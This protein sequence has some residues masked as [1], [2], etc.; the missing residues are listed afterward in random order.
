MKEKQIVENWGRVFNFINEPVSIH[1]RDFRIIRANRAFFDLLK[2]PPEE[3]IGKHCYRLLHDSIEPP[4]TCPHVR[5][6][7]TKS[8]ETGEV[9]CAFTGCP[10]EVSVS[11]IFDEDMEL[12]GTVHIIR[13]ITARKR[14]EHALIE[15][16]ERHRLLLKH[17]D[18][19]VMVHHM[20]E[21]VYINDA[22][23]R[24]V[25]A[26]T[27]GEVIGMNV[28]DFVHPD[29]RKFVK[30]R[31]QRVICEQTPLPVAEEKLVRLDGRVLYA[32]VSASPVT[33]YGRP[34]VQV[35]VRDITERKRAEE[36]IIK[37]NRELSA[38]YEVSSAL[39]RTIEMD[40]L[41]KTVLETIID[42][43]ILNVQK[44]GGIILIDGERM[45]LV[46][47]LGHSEEFIDLH[48][49]M[50]MGECLCGISAETGEIIISRNS[51][52]D[53]RHTIRYPDMKP[54]GHIIVPIKSK[55]GVIGVLYLY[56]PADVK[57]EADK[58]R[59]LSIIADQI[60]IAIENA[61]LYEE[62][63]R[64]SLH[65]PLTGLANRRFMDIM[66]QRL[67]AEARRFKRGFS[68]VMADIDHFKEFNDIRGHLEGDRLLRK[69]AEELR[70]DTRAVDLV[71]RYGG[72]E[73]V[74]LLTDTSLQK[75]R[76][77]A[78]IKRQR[79]ELSLPVTL[80]M[81][82]ATYKEDM[83]SPEDI[84]KVV[85]EALYRAKQKGRNRVEVSD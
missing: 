16:E 82:V 70:K 35:I 15:S 13:D 81:G 27:S 60:A 32:E 24:M 56:I 58:L 31:M 26:R 46:R 84:I 65:D 51:H 3:V 14:K 80:S 23:L 53:K 11:P 85:D 61:R 55:A 5:A 57:V 83:N 79:I 18:D 4:D 21:I 42:L 40:E 67:L 44:K 30:E 37:L 49:N 74:I 50:K 34:C 59:L 54:H 29:S 77:I 2:M 52:D 64:F 43:D 75:A 39:T 36:R 19:A 9:T 7:R 12:I 62:T 63:K 48:K 78:E 66:L 71:V 38:L 33:Y 28:M 8:H 68:V 20:G 69:I 41:F 47:H 72:E 1:D 25:G 17:L 73:F 45:R 10:L 22:G 6:L 76:R